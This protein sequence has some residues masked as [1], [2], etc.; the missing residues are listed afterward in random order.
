MIEG[1]LTPYVRAI[2]FLGRVAA[3]AVTRVRV[4]GALD[5]IPRDGPLIL[6]ANHASNADGVLVAGWMTPALRRRIHWLGKREMVEWPLVGRLVEAF[7]VHPVDRAGADVEAFR[8]AQR[9]L[10]QGHVLMVFPEGTRSAD[11]VLGRPRD[12]L[13]LLAL[14][15]DARIVP[16]GIAGSHRVWPRGRWPRVGGRVTMR[17]GRPFVVRADELGAADR[18]AAKAAATDR[19]M[20]EIAALLPEEQRGPYGRPVSGAHPGNQTIGR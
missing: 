16:I 9:I 5:E 20:R 10:D 11:G 17:V 14:R 19:I 6:A 2:A 4:E 18:R 3:R 8:L 13:A 12:G 15:S 7:G 1:R